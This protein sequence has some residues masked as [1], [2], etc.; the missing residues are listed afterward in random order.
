MTEM[1]KKVS[2]LRLKNKSFTYVLPLLGGKYSEYSNLSGCFVRDN[3]QTKYT[4]KI[5]LL[6]R[7]NKKWYTELHEWL[8]NKYLYNDHY[9]INE[10]YVMYVYNLPEG[11]EQNYFLFLKGK[12]SYMDDE[13]KNYIFKF[14]KDQHFDFILKL[15][16]ILYR[17][18]ELYLELEKE[19]SEPRCNSIVHI[20]RTQDVSSIPDMS[21]ETFNIDML[22]IKIEKNIWT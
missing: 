17:S 5:F 14:F 12:Y 9:V 20:P 21:K 2:T 19:L 10:E 15:R 6:Y 3:T 8:I 22:N 11:Y 13:Y 16:Q 18:E 4:D 7:N 1:V